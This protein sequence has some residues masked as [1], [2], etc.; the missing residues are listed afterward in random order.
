[1]SLGRRLK[2]DTLFRA[3]ARSLGWLCQQ[4]SSDLRLLILV[5]AP[6][7]ARKAGYKNESFMTQPVESV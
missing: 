1:M 5:I 4:K 7:A 2:G 3:G 6:Q